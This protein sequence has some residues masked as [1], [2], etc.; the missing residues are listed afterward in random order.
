M[1]MKTLIRVLWPIIVFLILFVI[2]V[3][4]ASGSANE[5]AISFIGIFSGLIGIVSIFINFQVL[6]KVKNIEEQRLKTISKIKNEIFF[7]DEI[8]R[9]K[10]AIDKLLGKTTKQEFLQDD[11][12]KELSIVMGI[13]KNPII[14]DKTQTKPERRSIFSRV[15]NMD[16]EITILKKSETMDHEINV[17]LIR[18]FR[19][20]LT[21]LQPILTENVAKS[22]SDSIISEESGAF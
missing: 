11:T 9:A 5:K 20:A 7:R 1:K 3:F 22:V 6:T 10:D 15:Q 4:L 2:S 16:E 21:E 14:I 19:E 12:T 13:C 17:N 8:T 18:N